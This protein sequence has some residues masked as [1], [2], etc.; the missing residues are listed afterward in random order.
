MSKVVETVWKRILPI[1]P[2]FT[3]AEVAERA[4]I[5][6]SNASRDLAKL[7]EKGMVTR[8][9]RG[10]WAVADHPDFSPYA[11]VPFLFADPGDLRADLGQRPGQTRKP[12]GTQPRAYV[13][14]LSALE[15]HG[16]IDQ[17]TQ[18]IQ[19]V[20]LQ[21]RST[22]KTPVGTFEFHG[23]QPE[24]FGG[25]EPY[26]VLGAFE[27]A[28]REKAVFDA[29]YLSVHRGRRFAHLPEL[30]LGQGFSSTEVD[31]WIGRIP[32]QHIR[33]AVTDR[34]KILVQRQDLHE[35]LRGLAEP[36]K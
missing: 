13:S 33:R 1:S 36:D 34:W 32:Q 35:Q 27:I 31:R 24:L 21:R 6:L 10:L 14:L 15:L 28:R 11:V 17:I 22:L 30:E 29:M 25:F 18:T 23:I 5:R 26:G 4:G 16:M 9:R 20:T 12:A 2:V 8:V 19:V 7:E 3:T